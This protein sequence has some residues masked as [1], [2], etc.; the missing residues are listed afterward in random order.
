MNMH[1]YIYI[2]FLQITVMIFIRG[3]VFFLDEEAVD[4]HCSSGGFH[5]KCSESNIHVIFKVFF[6]V[7]FRI[8]TRPKNGPTPQHQRCCWFKPRFWSASDP[9]LCGEWTLLLFSHSFQTRKSPTN[10]YGHTIE[11]TSAK[12]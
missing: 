10:L 3:F 7:H 9:Y 8:H 6:V 1:V 4:S 11:H 5:L 12:R 2:Y